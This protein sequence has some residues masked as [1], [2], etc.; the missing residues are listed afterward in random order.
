[1]TL[2][3]EHLVFVCILSSIGLLGSC[4]AFILKYD[5]DDLDTIDRREIIMSIMKISLILFITTV[6]T[7]SCTAGSGYNVYTT[8]NSSIATE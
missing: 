6:I 5:E 4:I 8:T 1:M 2:T 7:S 3:Y